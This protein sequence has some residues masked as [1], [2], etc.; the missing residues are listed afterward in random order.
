MDINKDILST[1][2]RFNHHHQMWLMEKIW[3]IYCVVR[4]MIMDLSIQFVCVIHFYFPVAFTT[5]NRRDWR[6]PSL[7]SD[8]RKFSQLSAFKRE[9]LL[10]DWIQLSIG[11]TWLSFAYAI[12][13]SYPRP[14]TSIV[15]RTNVSSG[16][17]G[18][19]HPASQM[20]STSFKF[21]SHSC[22]KGQTWIARPHRPEKRR[23]TLTHG[24]HPSK[25]EIL[26]LMVN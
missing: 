16:P 3:P 26:A 14:T 4:L 10:I 19:Q 23:R 11:A 6:S 25:S 13:T 15:T 21:E 7:S 20:W 5:Q 22:L 18:C 17:T 2:N 1:M 24:S 12:G 8:T 9:D